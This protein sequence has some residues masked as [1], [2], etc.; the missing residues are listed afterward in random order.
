MV[1]LHDKFKEVTDWFISGSIIRVSGE[2]SQNVC[3]MSPSEWFEVY[4]YDF[5][6]E[7]LFG[8][9][10]E[11]TLVLHSK[12]MKQIPLSE[13]RIYERVRCEEL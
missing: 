1:T 5:E 6:E 2:V 13:V 10:G 3:W 8:N 4:S 9:V 7:L 12:D 11:D